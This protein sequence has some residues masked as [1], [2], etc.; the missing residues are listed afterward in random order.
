MD[1]GINFDVS[2]GW[3]RLAVEV[4]FGFVVWLVVVHC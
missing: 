2:W 1:F 4:R 3:S